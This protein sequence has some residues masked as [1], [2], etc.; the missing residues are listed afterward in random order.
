MA[1]PCPFLG[2]RS[3]AV[4]GERVR[5]SAVAARPRRT[6]R[7]VRPSALVA[8]AI[9]QGTA[10][11]A[12]AGQLRS[13]GAI[14]IGAFVALVYMR[15]VAASVTSIAKTLPIESITTYLEVLAKATEVGVLDPTVH[16][17]AVDALVNHWPDDTRWS[18]LDHHASAA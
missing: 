13:E 2:S 8:D 9:S 1:Q 15:D 14:L 17:L 18:L 11:E 5:R 6:G 4:R 12:F 10:L 3:S 7:G 16:Q